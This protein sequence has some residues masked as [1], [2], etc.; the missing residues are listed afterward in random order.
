MP[1]ED[2]QI[3]FRITAEMER[4]LGWY[5]WAEHLGSQ[6]EVMKAALT[7]WLKAQEEKWGPPVEPKSRL[8]PTK[9]E[10][11]SKPA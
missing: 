10:P 7:T 9:Q 3:K 4:R 6:Q 8:K 2:K 1:K 11:S 5:M